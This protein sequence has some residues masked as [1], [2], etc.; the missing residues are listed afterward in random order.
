M[1][2]LLDLF[3][4]FTPDEHFDAIRI[5]LASP[6]KIHSWSFGEVKKPETINYRTFKPER[7]GLFCAKIFG[8]IKDYECLCGKYKRLKHRGVI[9]EK[10]GVEVTQTKVRRE[11]MGHIDLAAPCAHIWFLKSL[12]SRLGMVLDMT[13]RDIERVLY[14]EAYV[15]TDPGMTTLKKFS[16]MSEDDYDA[17]RKEFGD[18]FIAKM[19]AEGIKDLLESIDIELSIERLRG[20]LTGSEVKVK[21]NT[22]R[23]KVL[24]AFKKSGIKPEWMVLE[25]LPVLPPDLRP[26][27]PLDGGRFATSDLNDLYRRV[28]NRNSRLR[29]LL[30]LKAPE[31]IARNEKRML[32]E[33]VDSLLDNG[34]R[35]KAMTGA[36]KRALKSLADM[37]KGKSGRFR[38]NLL[39]KRV[40]YSGRSVITVGPTLK[41]HQCGLPKLM[42]LEL[43]KPF[44]FSRLEAMGIATT[45]KAAKKEVESGTPVVWDILEEVIKEHPVMLNRAPTLHRMGIQA[46]EPILIEGKAIQLHPLVCSAFNADFD[47][48][49]MA[50][51]VPLSVEAQMEART[52]MLASNNV[53]LPASGEPSIVPSQDVVLGLYYATRERINGKG[54]GLVFADTGEVQRAFDANELELAARI[55]VRLTEW[56]RNKESGELV[57]STALVETTAGR[58]LLSEILP[59]GLPFSHINKALKKKEISRLIN[60]SFRKCGLKETVVFA[61]RLLQNG[62]HLATRAGISIA[63][64]DMLVP[65]QKAAIIERSEKEVKEIEQQYISGLVTSGE[66]YNKVVDIWGKAGDEVSKAMM[67]RLSKEQVIDRHGNE[68]S[69]ESFNSIYMMSDSGARGSP[70][71]IRQV[72]GMR[73]LMA[74]PDGSIIETPITANFREGLNVLEYFISTHGARK[75]L[76]DTALK[77]ANSGYLTR[78]LVDV[79]QDLV[80]TEEDCETTNGSLMRAI[81][82][83]GEVIESLRDRIL[84]RTAAEDVLHPENRSVLLPAGAMF[85]EDLIEELQAAG[86][87]EVKV[88][89]ALTCETRYGLCAKCYGRDLGRGGLINLGEAVGVIAAQSIGEPGTQLT[90][91][92]FHIGGAASRAAIASSVEARSNGVIGFNATM[93][94]VSNTKGELVVIA[95]SGE[96]II[97]DEHGRERERHK[98]PYGA[99]LTAKADQS[100][101]AGTVLA[102]WD[103]L[104]RPIITEFAGRTKFENVEEGLTVAR[105]L[106]DVTGLSTLVVIDPK[107]RGAAK[108][109]RP[110]VKL[111]DAQ[112]N[113]VKIPGTDHS[114][115]IGFPVGSLIQVR[116]GQ[117]VGP[118]EVLAR[119]PVEGQKTR[120][121]TGGLPRVAELFEA[122]TPKDKGTLAE[123]TGTVSFGKET[124]GKVRLQIT[125]PEG[126][127][128]EELVP[129]EKNI[130]VHEGQVVNKGESIVDGPADPQDILRLLG[131]EELSRYIVDEVQDVYRLQGV[132]INDKHIEV[133]VRQMLRR[134]VVENAGE[135]QYINGEQVE[136]SE[137]L[138][139]NE[140]LLAAGKIPATYSNLLLG[141]TKA[142]LSTDSFIS[143]ASFQETTR[144][145]TEAAI[146]GKRDELR[147]LKENVIVGRLIPAGTGLAYHQARK[148]KDAMDDAERRAIAD[149][150]AAEM[151]AQAQAPEPDGSSMTV[152]DAAAD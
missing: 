91:R 1:K 131:I 135:S 78:R 54:E 68:V 18:E 120:D 97:H 125:D 62:F 17:K 102:T 129:K 88:R 123:M 116:D 84:G 134:V 44:I 20:D 6:E 122:R 34:R 28:I 142:S 40:D 82:E 133:I 86:V 146:M 136:R 144:V 60:V 112:G 93:R 143:A 147:G 100:V 13:L 141:I 63:I 115:T 73:G 42:A 110:Q 2:S 81:V 49:Q 24:E 118:G 113:E 5:G 50:V 8:P 38:Q 21:K 151:A 9:C 99:T 152:T 32:Q 76:A 128:F 87:D 150:E 31:I 47:G 10:C 138:N 94:Y 111:I 130:L 107:R 85:D 98:L 51:H 53:L 126:H 3:K 96:I 25:V 117:D 65:P 45:I 61:D 119:I 90:M 80:V 139:T 140:A 101:K 121:I 89:T 59:R 14:F 132:K 12:P 104:T 66:R 7:D 70:A 27:V 15:V 58:A 105:Q 46:F 33:A 77:T 26:L 114:V 69:Q 30:E 109:V 22:K 137:I 4:Q 145:L 29:R 124:K 79:T 48:D 149:A 108:V 19:G 55:T 43:F 37:I 72:A 83:G 67:A 56:I 95:R 36:N 57:A 64:D 16:I 92:T 39:G 23:L 103:P 106:D 127:V 74:K 52:L 35:G 41:L 148:A 71:Q 75:G 11:R